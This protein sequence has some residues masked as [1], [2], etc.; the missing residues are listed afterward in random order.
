MRTKLYV[1]ELR[2]SMFGTQTGCFEIGEIADEFEPQWG[3]E[4]NHDEKC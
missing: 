4:G 3:S 1:E 2:N